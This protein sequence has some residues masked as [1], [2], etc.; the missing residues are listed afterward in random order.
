[1]NSEWQS[2]KLCQAAAFA[3]LST[4]FF[5]CAVEGQPYQA[6]AI[7]P[8]KSAVYIYRPY[9]VL[10]GVLEFPVTCGDASMSLGPGGYHRLIVDP[11]PVRCSAHTE[12]TSA[13][14]FEARAGGS[15]YIRESL[16]FGVIEP[17]VHLE[18]K[19]GDE[20]EDEI[21]KCTEQ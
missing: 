4:L 9:S 20:S 18:L 8:A 2:M 14:E 6:A 3:I 19:S 11:G 10:G 21:R 15:Y 7:T 16:R 12:V 13:V 17:H 5:G 1:M